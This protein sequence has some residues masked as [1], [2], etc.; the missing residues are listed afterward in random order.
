MHFTRIYSQ[1]GEPYA[2]LT[3]SPRDST[4]T[5]PNGT[6]VFASKAIPFPTTWSQHAVDVVAQK[7]LRK[8]GVPA[9]LRTVPEDGV[10]AWLRRSVPDHDALARLPERERYTGENDARQ[11][12]R[13][14]AG[15][16]T[17]WAWKADYFDSE[18]DALTYY[19][20]M[21]AMLARQIASPNSPQ[22]FN[23]GLHWAY[24]IEGRPQ[25][26]WYV[27]FKTGET[28]LSENAYEHASPFACYIQSIKDDLVGEGGIFD[29][30]TR[31]A[32]IF[33][34]GGG[35][36]SSEALVALAGRGLTK[37]GDLFAE[38]S[39]SRPTQQFDKHSSY[40]DIS[41]LDIQ[42]VSLNKETG[43]LELDTIDR[44]W[45]YSVD[46]A[47]KFTVTFANG[48]IAT[49]SA[50][51]PFMVWD[52]DDIVEKRADHLHPGDAVIG[53]GR[54]AR[55]ALNRA[56]VRPKLEYRYQ[57]FRK[58]IATSVPLT[59]DLAWLIGYFIGDGS[60]GEQQVRLTRD[61]GKRSY[62]YRRL[63]LRFH[64]E[65]E[66]TLKKAQRILR[67]VFS[68]NS[69]IRRDN[70]SNG[71]TLNI[72]HRGACAFFANHVHLPGKKT[73]DVEVPSFILAAD[74]EI[75]AAFLAGLID[76]DCEAKDGRA[77]LYTASENLARQVSGLA[78]LLNCGGGVNR[79]KRGARVV[80][81]RKSASYDMKQSI[82]K[83]VAHEKRRHEV[84]RHCARSYHAIPISHVLGME[85]FP[86]NALDG[87]GIDALHVQT[88]DGPVHVGRLIYEGLLSKEKIEKAIASL[89]L[90]G[91]TTAIRRLSRICDQ[92][93]FV[94][95]VV[96][97]TENVPFND[98]TVRRNNTYLAGEYGLVVIHNSGSNFSNLRAAG[99][100]LS[101][102]GTSS[103][104]MSWLRVADRAAG[105]IKSG[106]TTRRAAKMCVL[107]LDHPDV[108]A[109]ISWKGDEEQK[110]A[111]LIAGAYACERHLNAILRAAHNPSLPE[112]ARYDPAT[113]AAL[114]EAIQ[115]ALGAAIPAGSI[116]T[117]LDYAKE[118]YT[119]LRI[120]TF[121]ADWEGEAYQTVSGQNANNS[122]RIPNAFFAALDADENWRLTA[123]TTG[124][125]MKSVPARELWQ[126]LTESAWR[127]ADPG[128]QFCD[129]I[130]EWHTIPQNGPINATNPC[131]EYC[132]IDDSACNLASI[133]L[134]KFSDGYTFDHARFEEVVRY[135]TFTLEVSILMGQLPSQVLAENTHRIRNLG[136]GYANLGTLLMRL[137]IPYDSEEAF[138]WCGA[139]TH[140]LGACAYRTS[141]EMAKEFG[142]FAD[143]AANRDDM[144]R[145]IRNHRTAAYGKDDF[146]GL[147]VRPVL[148]TPTLFTQ[149][150]WDRA[151]AA[152]DDALALG[153][154]HGFRNS[155]TT[156]IAPTGTIGIQMDCD[157]TGIEPD[158]AL[159]KFKK[160]AGGGYMKIVN[161]S[162]AP[163]LR[164][165]GYNSEHIAAIERF[166]KGTLSL[167]G[168]PHINRATLRA[169]GFGETQLNAI[170]AALPAAF[171][172]SFAFN[173]AVLGEDF[174]L[175]TLRCSRDDLEDPRFSILRHLGFSDTQIQEANAV[176]CGRMSLEGAPYLKDEHLPIFDCATPCGR[177]GTR[178]IRPL[179][180]VD[181][182]A[183]AQSA[184]SGS[185]SKTIN[186]PANATIADVARV[187]RYAH[188]RGVKCIS[189]YRDG[190]KLS[191]P[192]SSTIDLPQSPT[193][194][195]ASRDPLHIAERI[196]YR[197]IAKRR[198]LP[199]RRSG[200]T[201]KATVG[202]HKIYLRTGEYSDGTLGEI[203]IDMHKEG[204]A[205]RSLMN[206]FA[207]AISIGLQ[208]GV[209]LDEFV[210]AYTF[211]KFEPNGPVTGHD[212]IKMA[213]SVV[214]YIFRELAIA[215]LGRYELAH[216]Q[217][218]ISMDS[219]QREPE[220]EYVAEEPA[221]TPLPRRHTHSNGASNGATRMT[222]SQD[223]PRS[224]AVLQ[225]Y[226]GDACSECGQF[227]MVRSG[228]CLRCLSCSATSGC[229]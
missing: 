72:H 100:K 78:S 93:T 176:I 145:V 68:A 149:P 180:H 76:S 224:I 98:L 46:Q 203:F 150:I 199:A 55:N 105:A 175:S 190:C 33:K 142:P 91:Q 200:Y 178:S 119:S 13:R 185:I 71:R 221:N 60:L 22:W 206:S 159:V 82:T 108:E 94:K 58:S 163:A 218:E 202:G 41:D 124:A 146:I 3:F 133:N 81:V 28:K 36:I 139:I 177:H 92:L 59:E 86:G 103:G 77:V 128:V 222:T 96:P 30:Y 215:Y 140:L 8:T 173:R 126:R 112:N 107:D 193:G 29:F 9:V 171:E 157:T 63:R 84:T 62:A 167:E 217:P 31:E 61:Y 229:S 226:S 131:A 97:T 45:A 51:H 43:E 18:A 182:M 192:L 110:V 101:G 137:G 83:Y 151:R 111:D 187:Y 104:L 109:F 181:M 161:E 135:W 115:G 127:C 195:T 32:R 201:Q 23:T 174:C 44:V 198:K 168:A 165:L 88:D 26:H 53:S 73:Y 122:V 196:V 35:C 179:A 24:G 70:R 197:Y 123:R 153:E 220:P 11:A 17:Y 130:N 52:G 25:G 49:V 47:D 7:Y 132:S 189:V 66:D 4:I 143:F 144:L 210:D 169:K 10:P 57:K 6:V 106:G 19:E 216:V 67:N 219:V 65:T 162:I 12:F 170:E 117:A 120:E 191:Q 205:F 158:F 34:H 228:T 209:P 125:T 99:E 204:A 194:E 50:W 188:E 212:N 214:D 164:R 154:L 90:E 40:I 89:P 15:C 37:I 152:W 118:G 39:K 113:N 225:G 134:A 147:S 148:H 64:D 48:T 20:E 223:D 80:I 186:M 227:T 141:A 54:T 156:L 69:T 155:Q 95:E 213:T 183:A 85:L 102:G 2:G 172:L 14:L 136:L 208:H 79:K 211:T 5:E 160:L 1:P 27:D 75:Q 16:W 87:T 138:G 38:V 184:L 21:Q 74:S 56:A 114:R 42:T 207:I 116:R 166:A 121:D 129:T